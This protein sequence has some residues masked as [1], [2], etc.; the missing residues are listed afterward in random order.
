MM[1]V[2]LTDKFKERLQVEY[3]NLTKLKYSLGLFNLQ[4]PVLRESRVYEHLSNVD[5]LKDYTLPDGTFH[6]GKIVSNRCLKLAEIMSYIESVAAHIR[7]DDEP[8]REIVY[9]GS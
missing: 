8:I 3:D 6:A 1:I 2:R 4:L 9:E 5:I 7:Y